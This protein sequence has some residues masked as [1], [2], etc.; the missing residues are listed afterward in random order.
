MKKILSV[1]LCVLMLTS[2]MSMLVMPVEAASYTKPATIGPDTVKERITELRNKLEGKYFTTNQKSDTNYSC[3][4][5]DNRNIITKSWFKTMFSSKRPSSTNQFP[6]YQ[7]PTATFY[8]AGWSCHGFGTFA[9][10]YIF[11]SKSTDDINVKKIGTIDSKKANFVAKAKMGDIIRSNEPTNSSGHTAIFLSAESTGIKVLQSNWGGTNKVTVEVIKYSKYSKWTISRATNYDVDM[12]STPT[13]TM[14]HHINGGAIA[15]KY[16]VAAD[17]VGLNLRSSASTSSSVLVTIPDDTILTVTSTKTAGGYTWGKATYN[18][19]TGWCAL[20]YTEKYGYY[21]SSSLIYK[22]SNSKVV[23]LSWA[24]GEGGPNGLYNAATFGISKSGYTFKGW[25]TKAD[26]SAEIFD[27]NNEKLKAETIYPALSSGSKTITLYAIW[28]PTATFTFNTNANGGV[29]TAATSF[30]VKPYDSFTIPQNTFTKQNSDFLYWNVKRS[31]DNKWLANGSWYTEAEIAENG[32]AK[33]AYKVGTSYKFDESWF[34]GINSN[35]TYTFYAVWEENSHVHT[36]QAVSG[37]TPTCTESGLTSGV[38]CSSCGAV[39]TAQQELEAVG[40]SY[41]DW[42]I[43]ATNGI[44]TQ[45]CSTC[46]DTV[47]E[48]YSYASG[49]WNV[50]GSITWRLTKDGMLTLSGSGEMKKLSVGSSP[51]AEYANEIKSLVISDG[52]TT[53]G[54]RA[55]RDLTSLE[56]VTFGKDVAS[57]GY[58]AFYNCVSLTAVSF[59]EG[60]K[61]IGAL[62]FYNT[63]IDSI[64]LPS[65]LETINSR[66]FKNCKKLGFVSIPDSVTY[67]GYEVFMNNVSLTGF[68]LSANINYINAMMFSGCTALENI[69]IPTTVYAIKSNA[70]ANSGLKTVDFENSDYLYA[71]G[72]LAS[73]IFAG[74]TELT[75]NAWSSSPAHKL[76]ISKGYTFKA[77]NTTKFKYAMNAD[78]TI[79]VTGLYDSTTNANIPETIDGYTVTAIGKN[80]FRGKSEIKSASIPST[81]TTL[82][83]RAFSGTSITWINIPESMVTIDYQAFENCTKLEYVTFLGENLDLINTAAFNGCIALKSVVGLDKSA[84]EVGRNAFANCSSLKSLSLSSDVTSINSTAFT[85][86]TNLTISCKKDSPA[87][88]F[89]VKYGITY[90]LI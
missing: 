57:V 74:C 71:S 87:Y 16:I 51:V 2:M 10:W 33:K 4:Y 13:L 52:I 44:C 27:E 26:G 78:G 22:C 65:T 1:L 69:T 36:E 50:D 47:I 35:T 29:G 20:D 63:A 12:S 25:C 30:T 32:Y 23:T 73:N 5:C 54:N 82:G 38:K 72:A 83:G 58:E 75:V 85:G 3:D 53:I 55:F 17:G 84:L 19:K 88:N 61:S 89:A 37:K 48:E 45:T 66:A 80:A 46:G 43:D 77:K 86:A 9:M 56:S 6:S 60:L 62:A 31:N 76:A 49:D 70:F 90:K 59:N 39:L 7:G 64:A 68:T 28:S 14:K 79:T 24:L 34:K 21:A 81:V 8:P 11:A 42:V 40:H 41:G 18:G 67:I 15:T